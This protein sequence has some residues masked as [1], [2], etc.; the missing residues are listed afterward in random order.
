MTKPEC[1]VC[2]AVNLTTVEL[3][4]ALQR[5]GAPGHWIDRQH[6]GED[7]MILDYE[8]NM[9]RIQN[10]GQSWATDDISG[11]SAGS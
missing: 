2:S 8:M 5:V 6:E 4:A 3:E 7:N 9:L 1:A 11:S 10:G